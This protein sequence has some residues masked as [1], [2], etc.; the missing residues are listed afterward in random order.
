MAGERDRRLGRYVV[1][2]SDERTH[3]RQALD[4]VVVVAG[5]RLGC[6]PGWVAP[7]ARAASRRS[8]SAG[9]RRA[10]KVRRLPERLEPHL[11]GA[12]VQELHRHEGDRL[13]AKG[14]VQKGAS[15][16]SPSAVASTSRRA[17]S[18]SNASSFSGGTA[19]VIRSWASERKISHGA[20]PA[21]LSGALATVERAPPGASAISPT[22]D[23]S[24][25]APLSV[26]A[27]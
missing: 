10:A 27:L 24:P 14:D 1:V 19:R 23:D 13:V 20:S 5:L 16:N 15:V 9:S 26:M 17:A 2:D 8:R 12:F 11:G 25:P 22:D 4:L 3:H 7:E 18:S 21:Y 6:L